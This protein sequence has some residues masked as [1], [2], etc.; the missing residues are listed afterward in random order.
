MT[1]PAAAERA[2][3][4]ELFLAVGPDAPTLSGEWTTRDLAAHLVVR[5]RRPD[6]GPGIVT[7]VLAEYSERVRL[8][9]AERPYDEIVDRVRRGPP[10]W[11]PMRVDA[12]DR[13]VN[14]IEFFVHHEDVRRGGATFT[15]RNLEP[16]LDEALA[17]LIVP[18]GKL[19]TRKST[20]GI[21][22][23]PN[24]HAAT[25]IHRGEPTVAIGGPIGE[26]VLFLYGR[27]AASAAELDGPADAVSEL[28]ATALGI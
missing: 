21:V 14:T 1:S 24:G 5:E 28:R 3:L 20:V 16:A 22:L 23:A 2:L 8:A 17:S 10:R 19:L 9:E 15:P 4:C 11:S 12:V 18:A 13:L 26:C 25:T 6:A 27:A 7:G